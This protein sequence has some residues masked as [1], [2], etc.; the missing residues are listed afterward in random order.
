MARKFE[1]QIQGYHALKGLPGPYIKWFLQSLGHEGLNKLLA[2][3]EDKSAYAQS[4]GVLTG[5]FLTSNF[6][7]F[8]VLAFLDLCIHTHTQILTYSMTA[9]TCYLSVDCSEVS[10]DARCLFT[11]CAGPGKEVRVFDGRTEGKIV[12]ARCNLN[13]FLKDSRGFYF[14]SYQFASSNHENHGN[15]MEITWKLS[16]ETVLFC[17]ADRREAPKTS[18]GIPFLSRWKAV[19]RPSRR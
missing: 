18:V 3:Y 9:M 14:T 1:K 16:M 11:L 17:V 19:G 7:D 2:G 4:L 5:G 13:L 15:H 12:E 6:L 10:G 8:K